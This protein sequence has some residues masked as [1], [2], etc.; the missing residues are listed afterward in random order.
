[1]SIELNCSNGEVLFQRPSK[2]SSKLA[3]FCCFLTSGE[4]WLEQKRSKRKSLPLYSETC[5]RI[6][7]LG[8][9]LKSVHFCKSDSRRQGQGCWCYITQPAQHKAKVF[10]KLRTKRKKKRERETTTA[11]CP[12][13][14]QHAAGD[15]AQRN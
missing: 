12:V 7:K 10:D 6:F 13:F 9:R 4:V 3:P 8:G 14:A 11:L 2:Q 15:E 1:M 5:Q